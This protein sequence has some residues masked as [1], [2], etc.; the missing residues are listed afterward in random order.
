MSTNISNILLNNDI[1]LE[2]GTNELEVLV[3]RVGPFRLGINVAKVSEVLP[4]QQ[5]TQMPQGHP[6]IVGCFRLRDSIVS[7]VSLHRHLRQKADADAD[8]K[9]ILAEFN[10]FQHAYLVDDIERIHRISW[11]HIRPVPDLIRHVGAPLTAVAN[12]DC[13]LVLMVDF[14][15]IAAEIAYEQHGSTKVANEDGIPRSEVR[16]LIA[17]DSMTVRGALETT[18]RNSGYTNVTAFEHGKEVWDWLVEHVEQAEDL[19]EV[20]NLLVSDVEMPSMDGLHL[21]RKIKSDS[22]FSQ[23]PV[24]LYSSI[25]TP[26]NRRKGEAVGANA[27][28]TKPEL[29]RVVDLA[30]ELAGYQFLNALAPEPVDSECLEPAGV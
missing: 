8:A 21:T 26:A 19:P 13:E 16:I 25:L 23:L 22:R 14:E 9:L 28:I 3:F 18:L 24:V 2:S 11:E 5:I 20:A 12:V 30:D 15:S 7:C 1:L 10:H 4:Y 27:Q 6:S 29:A 17:D